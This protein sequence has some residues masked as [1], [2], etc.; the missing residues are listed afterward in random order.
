LSGNRLVIRLWPLPRGVK[1]W[2][3]EWER[4]G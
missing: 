4:V 3:L 1:E 2:T